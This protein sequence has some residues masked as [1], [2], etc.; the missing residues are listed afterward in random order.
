M[1]KITRGFADV[2]NIFE[3]S[4][5]I[6]FDVTDEHEQSEQHRL[7]LKLGRGAKP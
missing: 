1:V 5:A 6:S 2:E 4:S 7:C 3:D